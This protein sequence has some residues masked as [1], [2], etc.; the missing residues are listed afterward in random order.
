M[1]YFDFNATAPLRPEARD[2]W[3][4]ASREAWYNPSS[5]Y[6]GA[7]RTRSL[8]EQARARLG[9]ILGCAAD[10]IVFTSGATESANALFRH[11]AAVL[12]REARVVLGPTEHPCVLASARRELSER[13]D[14][15]AVD[16]AGRVELGD[17]AQR[18]RS[19]PPAAVAVMAANN[20]TG[21]IQP[22]REITELCRESRVPYICDA[23]QWLGKLPAGG[24]GQADFLFGA[25]HKFGAPKGVGFL[26]VPPG[27]FSGQTGGE[28]EAGRRGGT[29]NYP[30]VAAI[31]AALSE[32]ETAKV[33]FEEDRLQ[34]RR[35]FERAIVSRIPGA[36][37]LAGDADRLWNTVP[38]ILPHFDNQRWVPKIDR[39]G[40]QVSTGSACA[41]GKEGPS[42]VLAAMGILPDEARR[43]IRVSAGWDTETADWDGLADALVETWSELQAATGT[44]G[45]EV[46]SI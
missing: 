44:D 14:L 24:L 26:K 36:R 20:E 41:T 5:P 2:A 8:L 46:I 3:L 21:V 19:G 6:R 12:P 35:R 40:Y 45:T 7:A 25:G 13:V 22:W 33:L 37:V 30:A 32:A 34:R 11:L 9:E 1:P 16:A 39:R 43:M 31:L 38:L 27:G 17:L 4:E 10:S 42:H 18:L 15:L 29:E 28:Q 23:A